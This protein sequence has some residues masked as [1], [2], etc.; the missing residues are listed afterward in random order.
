MERDAS[1]ALRAR[2]ACSRVFCIESWGAV[3]VARS[4]PASNME[5]L[6]FIMGAKREC[7]TGSDMRGSSR[8]TAVRMGR[9]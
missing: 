6:V 3:N 7:I 2:V 4:E 8:F 1:Y 5:R 9:R